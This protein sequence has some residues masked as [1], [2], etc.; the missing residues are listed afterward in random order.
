[1]NELVRLSAPFKSDAYI[2]EIPFIYYSIGVVDV[3][4]GAFL[5]RLTFLGRSIKLLVEWLS[6]TN[7]NILNIRTHVALKR[8]HLLRK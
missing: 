4:L 3:V 8:T 5:I 2:M 1:M 7:S 6:P